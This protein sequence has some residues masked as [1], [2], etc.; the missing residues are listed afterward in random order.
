MN[1]KQKS[2]DVDQIMKMEIHCKIF[3]PRVVESPSDQIE[4]SD[5]YH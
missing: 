1:L 2:Y 5:S 4:L 3:K